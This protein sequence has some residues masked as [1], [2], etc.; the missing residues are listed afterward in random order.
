[1]VTG[2]VGSSTNGLQDC[3][4][5]QAESRCNAGQPPLAQSP[6]SQL[7]R[8]EHN[9]AQCLIDLWHPEVIPTRFRDEDGGFDASPVSAKVGGAEADDR[10]PGFGY[11]LQLYVCTVHS[12]GYCNKVRPGTVPILGMERSGPNPIQFELDTH[13]W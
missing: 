7:L 8:L 2:A 10:P 13:S 9:R 12:R 5:P 1:M 4:I 11:V 6:G 3:F